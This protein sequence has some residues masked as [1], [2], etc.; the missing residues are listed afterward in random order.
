MLVRAGG[1]ETAASDVILSAQESATSM[2]VQL[3]KTTVNA[4]VTMNMYALL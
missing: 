4:H 3:G 1:V 2:A